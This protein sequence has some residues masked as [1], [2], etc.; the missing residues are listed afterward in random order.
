MEELIPLLFPLA[1]L[2]LGYFVGTNIEKKHYQSIRKR[3]RATL[4]VPVVTFGAKQALPEA[5]ETALFVGSVVIS[6]DYFKTFLLALRNLVGGRIQSYESLLDRARREALLRLKE[7][8]IAWGA[9][10]I[11][12]VRYETASVGGQTSGNGIMSVEVIAYG[13][14]VR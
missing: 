13:T 2:A 8:A 7:D 1:L 6:S 5:T 10:E 9:T 4:H 11:Y 3:E 14:A 12:N